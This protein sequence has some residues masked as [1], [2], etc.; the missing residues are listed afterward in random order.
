MP[1]NNVR[2]LLPPKEISFL[3]DLE[4]ISGEFLKGVDVLFEE[5]AQNDDDDQEFKKIHKRGYVVNDG[6]IVGLSL[7]T[8]FQ[9]GLFKYKD[10][11]KPLLE[12]PD[13]IG[14][15]KK[16][17]YL[18]LFGNGLSSAI[19][20]SIYTLDKL[21]TLNLGVNLMLE[22]DHSIG[23]LTKLKKLSLQY[24]QLEQLPESLYDLKDLEELNIAA[25]HFLNLSDSIVN[26]K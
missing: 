4:R 8:R 20:S 9:T 11:G 12:L 23:N 14:N 3:K 18:D 13:T 7:R 17:K 5:K 1:E 25:N 22:L 24:N 19:P 2:D 21:E 15:L 6:H 26:L 16:L 10:I